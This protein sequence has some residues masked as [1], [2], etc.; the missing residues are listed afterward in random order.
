MKTK[1]DNKLSEELFTKKKKKRFTCFI[2]S[3]KNY[4]KQTGPTKQCM[5]FERREL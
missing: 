3:V 1:T 4:T 5:G 2:E